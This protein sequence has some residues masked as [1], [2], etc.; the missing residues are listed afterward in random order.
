PLGRPPAVRGRHPDPGDGQAPERG[1]GPAVAAVGA[2]DP[3]GARSAG[4]R[5]SCQEPG[6]PAAERGGAG[7]G[8]GGDRG[9][10]LGRPGSGGVVAAESARSRNPHT[11]NASERALTSARKDS[12]AG[13]PR[14]PDSQGQL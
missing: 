11:W 12:N 1:A 13:S 2:P 4:A 10:A 8:A 3:G 6:R 7:G 5:L 9:R 14:N